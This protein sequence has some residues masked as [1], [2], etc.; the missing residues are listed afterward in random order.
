MEALRLPNRSRQHPREGLPAAGVQGARASRGPQLSLSVAREGCRQLQD[1]RQDPIGGLLPRRWSEMDLDMRNDRLDGQ[2][3]DASA[4]IR[5]PAPGLLDRGLVC[6]LADEGYASTRP[7]LRMPMILGLIRLIG[8]TRPAARIADVH[9][10]ARGPGKIDPDDQEVASS[11]RTGERPEQRDIPGLENDGDRGFAKRRLRLHDPEL[12]DG[13]AE[14]AQRG[15]APEDGQATLKPAQ[16]L[17]ALSDVSLGPER[18]PEHDDEDQPDRNRW[19]ER[20]NRRHVRNDTPREPT[21]RTP[22]AGGA[23][24]VRFAGL[25]TALAEFAYGMTGYEFAR[26]AIETRA[27]MENVFM[28]VV[29]GDMVGL[30]VLP[31]YY[32]MRLLPFV[33]PEITAWKRR[34]LRER[35]FTDKHDLHLHGV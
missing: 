29:V 8:T 32:S 16:K 34:V 31:P 33:V 26:H 30:P 7:I 23:R 25:R 28:V 17:V 15:P 21:E 11:A 2:P 24:A 13:A 9:A 3:P 1:R 5:Q 12:D 19:P 10:E 20:L 6:T 22:P 4:R 27:T 14:P 35:E 18:E